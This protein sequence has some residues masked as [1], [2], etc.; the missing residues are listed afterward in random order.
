MDAHSD[1]NYKCK[2]MTD[3][4]YTGTTVINNIPWAWEEGDTQEELQN[5]P[6]NR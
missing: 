1:E 4:P 3:C 2:E 6:R 5:L